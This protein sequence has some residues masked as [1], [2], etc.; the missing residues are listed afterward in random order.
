MAYRN[1]IY[2]DYKIAAMPTDPNKMYEFK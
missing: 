2:L 1:N